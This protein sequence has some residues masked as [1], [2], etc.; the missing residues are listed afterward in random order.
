MNIAIAG[1]SGFVGSFLKTY[2][3]E[4]EYQVIA[5]PRATFLDENALQQ[6]VNWADVVINLAGE[7]ILKRWSSSYKKRLL[8]SR[9]KST[10]LL[11]E[12]M[13]HVQKEQLF[14]SS[15]AIGIYENDIL[16]DEEDYIYG[17]T[18]LSYMCQEWE[19]EA[20][21]CHQRTV[22][23]RLGVVLGDGGGALH[24][25]ML[26]F[27]AGLGGAI[28]DGTQAFSFVHIDDLARAYEHV[29]FHDALEG[30]FNLS[31]PKPSTNAKFTKS[32]AKKLHRPA[33]V[34]VPP[35]ALKA[36]Y[37]EG[38]QVLCKGQAVYP[39]RLLESGFSFEYE[40]AESAIEDLVI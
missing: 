14:I 38:A 2:F 13:N 20:K 15:S 16:C 9:V 18:F 33:L 23:F 32:L 30:V 40:D 10:M 6:V 7:S 28:G 11:A 21:R 27:K 8:Q 35:I 36:V 17:E 39:K 19:K 22:I 37:G 29:I 4:K 12:A 1:A 5:I 31:S 34:P 26:P 25:M 24:K 3:T